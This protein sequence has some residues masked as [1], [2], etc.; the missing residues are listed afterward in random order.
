MWEESEKLKGLLG[1][2]AGLDGLKNSQP[3][4]VTSDSKINS[5]R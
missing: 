3:F 5:S 4:Q 2:E 1:M